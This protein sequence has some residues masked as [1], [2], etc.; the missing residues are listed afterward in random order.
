MQAVAEDETL[1]WLVVQATLTKGWRDNSFEDG[2]VAT[3]EHNGEVRWTARVYVE[4]ELIGSSRAL[5]A[6]CRARSA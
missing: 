3:I 2:A 5:P 6:S 4:R 1:C